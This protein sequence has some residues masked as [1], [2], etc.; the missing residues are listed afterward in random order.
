MPEEKSRST[1]EDTRRAKRKQVKK[2]AALGS[3]RTWTDDPGPRL[4]LWMATPS[5]IDSTIKPN[6]FNPYFLDLSDY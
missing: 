4:L 3:Y 6:V 5:A 2:G 1:L